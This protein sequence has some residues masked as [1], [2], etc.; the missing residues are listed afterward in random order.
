[1]LP[2][3]K[4][5]QRCKECG[6]ADRFNFNLPDEIWD[7][8]VPIRLRNRV[9]CL[10]CFDGFAREKG[11][12]YAEHLHI[13]YFAGEAAV[14]ILQV[15]QARDLTVTSGNCGSSLFRDIRRTVHRWLV[16]LAVRRNRLLANLSN[17]DRNAKYPYPSSSD[18]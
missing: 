6:L 3:S 5:Q 18:T 11:I 1:M 10:S 13:L 9:V 4:Q 15:L 2:V 16:W 7:A 14:F 8:V 17:S 12:A